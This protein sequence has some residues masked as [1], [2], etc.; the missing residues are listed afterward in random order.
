MSKEN[1]GRYSGQSCFQN[2]AVEALQIYQMGTP[3]SQLVERL[4]RVSN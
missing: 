2:R 1:D 4:S 3:L